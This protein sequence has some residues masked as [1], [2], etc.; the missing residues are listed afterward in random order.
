MNNPKSPKK[1][2]TYQD[3]L[4]EYAPRT[5]RPP[6]QLERDDLRILGSITHPEVP[7]EARDVL[8]QSVD[9]ATTNTRTHDL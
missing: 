1:R 2:Y 8:H 5:G 7:S 9:E 3:Y 6:T 4:A